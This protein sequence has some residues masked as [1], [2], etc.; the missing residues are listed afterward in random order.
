MARRRPPPDPVF[1]LAVIL[2][3]DS[4]SR[5]PVPRWSPMDP[6]CYYI[7][8]PDGTVP[9]GQVVGSDV[10]VWN[11]Y[12]AFA[13]PRFETAPCSASRIRVLEMLDESVRRKLPRALRR[14][15]RIDHS[16]PW[17]MRAW[18][19]RMSPQEFMDHFW[20]D[21]VEL[22][23]QPAEAGHAFMGGEGAGA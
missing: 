23:G 16:N 20:G 10:A 5:E 3:L 2:Q 21:L 14:R 17:S 13:A 9:S 4:I 15:F 22:T 1:E 6:D 11:L 12:F 7:R 8:T 19:C 18:M